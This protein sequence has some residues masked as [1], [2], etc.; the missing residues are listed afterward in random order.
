MTTLADL[1][2]W[3]VPVTGGIVAQRGCC[4]CDTPRTT[5]TVFVRN[6]G[7]HRDPR[8]NRRRWVADVCSD[9]CAL[10]SVLKHAVK[11]CTP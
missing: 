3:L 11:E 7:P 6:N 2:A 4:V 10:V 1:G 5:A 9:E 8:F